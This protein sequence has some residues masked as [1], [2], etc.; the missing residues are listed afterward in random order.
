MNDE[1]QQSLSDDAKLV[2]KSSEVT[3][4]QILWQLCL[5]GWTEGAAE[6]K[7]SYWEIN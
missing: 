5:P 4:P 6:Y 7:G 3:D 2:S 1:D